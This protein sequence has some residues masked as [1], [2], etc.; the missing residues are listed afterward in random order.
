[1]HTVYTVNAESGVHIRRVIT[2]SVC[3]L[4]EMVRLH[5][6]SASGP[7]GHR[8][9][10]AS[11]QA[12]RA[13]AGLQKSTVPSSFRRSPAEAVKNSMFLTASQ[14]AGRDSGILGAILVVF[15][16]LPLFLLF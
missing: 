4:Y 15:A 16:P 14:N 7:P 5:I 1:M 8:R 13:A 3:A 6:V 12:G 9:L 11:A 2:L 10:R